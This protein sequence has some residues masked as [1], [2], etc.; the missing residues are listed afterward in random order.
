MSNSE[1]L[2]DSEINPVIINITDNT[3]SDSEIN[4]E[5]VTSKESNDSTDGFLGELAKGIGSMFTPDPKIV[6]DNSVTDAMA[7]TVPILTAPPVTEPTIPALAMFKGP[8]SGGS[9]I[10]RDISYAEEKYRMYKDAYLI[11]KDVVEK[12]KI[13]S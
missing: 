6:E 3:L 2:S 4:A 11:L 7:A 8:M 10:D 12:N 13:N 9:S 5:I 1:I